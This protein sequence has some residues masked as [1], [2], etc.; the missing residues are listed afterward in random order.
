MPEADKVLVD[1]RDVKSLAPQETVLLTTGSQ[2]EPGAALSRIA[3]DDHRDVKIHTGD[4]VIFSASPIPGNEVGIWRTVN[5]LYRRG[6]QVIT[7]R[8]GG[9]AE[10][11][12][13]SGHGSKEEIRDM[14]NFVKPKY[15]I[16]IHGEYRHLHEF[17]N[18]AEEMGIGHDRVMLTEIGDV[19]EL[20]RSGMTKG[21]KIEAGA[22][23]VDGLTLGVTNAVLRDR[24]HLAE[25]GVLVVTFALDAE[26]GRIVAG[27]DFIARGLFGENEEV[28]DFYDEAS[29]RVLRAI[30]R[31]HEPPEHQVI[32]AKTREVMEAYAY[33]HWKRRPM[34]LPIVTEV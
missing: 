7:R 26:T 21:K 22:V 10:Q 20:R 31:L 33:H 28:K 16:P 13:V 19:V 25:E 8:R 32:V 18:L 6:A 14:I 34:V 2:G 5:N 4:T 17:R 1:M 9:E 23:M 15:C 24:Q 30:G 29:R 3:V 12:H 27:P 11:V